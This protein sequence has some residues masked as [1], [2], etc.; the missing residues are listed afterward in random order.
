MSRARKLLGSTLVA[1]LSLTA[2]G[3]GGDSGTAGRKALC[4]A[5]PSGPPLTA[6][7]WADGARLFAGLGDLH[8]AVNTNSPQ[9]QAYFDQGMR[10]LWAF[11]HDE[12]TRSFAKAAQLDPQCAMCWWGVALTV[13]P[14]YNLPMMAE[15]RGRSRLECPPTGAEIRRPGDAG[16]AG[17]DRGSRQTLPECAAA[18]PIQ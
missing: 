17:A 12:A 13:G 11:N 15:P 9:A 5:Q 6:S 18:R 16:R 10:F 8:R 1:A 7:Q 4:V 2:V 14:N 3:A